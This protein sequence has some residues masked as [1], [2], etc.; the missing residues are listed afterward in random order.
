MTP[1]GLRAPTVGFSLA[2][3]SLAAS[4]LAVSGGCRR[5]AEILLLDLVTE[6]GL[7]TGE[8]AGEAAAPRP[9]VE[10]QAERLRLPA[11]SRLETHLRLPPGA[12]LRAERLALRGAGGLELGIALRRA[13]EK[14]VEVVRLAEAKAPLEIELPAGEQQISRL[15]LTVVGP[16]EGGEVVL[17]A[18]RLTAPPPSAGP[19]SRPDRPAE[20]P[21][22]RP[23]GPS[24][25]RRAAGQ[26]PPDLVVYLV[27]TLRRDRLGVYGGPPELSPALDRFARGATVFE[28]AVA[29]SPWTRAAVASLFTGLEPHRHA[30]NNR[31]DALAPEALTAAE[32]L[33]AAG[34]FTAAVITNGNV[35]RKFGF[36]Q[37]FD[38]FSRPR[39][40][41][42]RS[43][44]VHQELV[45]L[46][47]SAELRRPFF[48]FVL[49]MDPHHPYRPRDPFRQR[50]ARDPE[51]LEV[52]SA[53]HLKQFRRGRP[54]AP[55]EAEQVRSLYDA[56]VAANDDS[57]GQ[58]LEELRR[59]DL[60][61]G[62]LIA[63]LS[64]HG[65]E[66]WE[67]GN[68]GHGH[69]VHGELLDIPLVVKAPGRAWDE[70]GGRRVDRLVQQID[71]L[72]TLLDYAGLEPPGSL[73]GVSLRPALESG[74][75]PAGRAAYSVLDLDRHRGV[76]LTEKGW[77]LI[78]PRGAAVEAPR[79]F[80][81]AADPGE[82][83]PLADA[84]PVVRG[85]LLARL[86]RVEH[87]RGQAL[88]AAIADMDP[89]LVQE[90]KALGY[91]Q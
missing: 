47:D 87:Q 68:W 79:V 20:P 8:V 81:L 91:L 75:L 66:F 90:L 16:A 18:P 13:F 15:T 49:T 58:L 3:W 29:Q 9:I 37:G 61:D 51:D 22:R 28:R 17:I 39:R 78:L 12:R 21:S 67:H 27:D 84:D 65:E 48:L 1:P 54:P 14:E 70:H 71:L 64:D 52:G 55:E 83:R 5:P 30:V 46:L 31:H 73:P 86:R 57:F 2:V 50:F 89:E 26:P 41:Q 40:L 56:A 6:A 24:G 59:R 4:L 82:Q 34:Y 11:G 36:D 25:D 63:F 43:D 77:K 74:A 69:T 38:H 85:Y 45:E 42:H 19:G 32:L 72:P 62:A 44:A 60:Y 88:T 76:G 35:G 53:E 33:S 7:A 23:P 10:P 80:D